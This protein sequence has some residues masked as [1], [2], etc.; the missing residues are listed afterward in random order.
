MVKFLVDDKEIEAAEGTALLQACLDHDIYIPNLCYVKDMESPHTSCRLCFVE[1]DGQNSP[2]ASCSVKV[3]EGMAVRTDTPAVRRLQQTAFRFLMSM[4]EIK[5]KTCPA[6]KKCEL[7]RIAKFLKVGLAS[8]G[9]ERHLKD[10]ETDE[11]HPVF[12][13]YPNRCVLC[14][15]CIY[16]CQKRHGRPLLTFAKRGIDTVISF[17]GEEDFQ[18][19]PG[20]DCAA[21]LDICPVSAITLKEKQ[22]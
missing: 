18:N 3:R 20:E 8:K 13:Y 9:L 11:S 22:L 7:R 17:Y 10:V 5:C 21:C 1:I 6:D 4:H 15:R 16:I 12:N 2:V 19:L 14:G